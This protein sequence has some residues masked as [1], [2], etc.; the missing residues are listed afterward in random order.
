MALSSGT[1]YRLIG[2]TAGAN[3]G[4]FGFSGFPVSNSDLSVTSGIFSDAISPGVWGAFTD[5]TTT[6][7][8]GVPEPGTLALFALGCVALV[9]C[10][11][12]VRR[13]NAK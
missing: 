2:I 6:Q 4:K 7:Q 5:L 8:Q 10:R 13:H 12:R 9:A 1:V 11:R 3:N